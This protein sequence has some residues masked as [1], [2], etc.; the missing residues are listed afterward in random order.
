MYKIKSKRVVASLFVFIICTSIYLMG[1]IRIAGDVVPASLLPLSIAS[2]HSIYLD[3][4]VGF[5]KGNQVNVPF[6]F[7]RYGSHYISAYPITLPLII[8]PIYMMLQIF[9]NFKNMPIGQLIP[10]A[11][12]IGKVISAILTALSVMFFFIFIESLSG[13]RI[14][15]ILLSFIYAFA[16]ENWAIASNSLWQHGFSELM[17]VLCFISILKLE[18]NTQQKA[19]AFLLGLFVS[20]AVS[21]RP[22]DLV[23]AIPLLVYVLLYKRE[24]VLYFLS[25]PFITGGA[26]ITYNLKYFGRLSGGYYSSFNENIFKGVAGLLLS[27]GRGLFVYTPIAIFSLIGL[28]FSF[29]D[30]KTANKIY[31]IAS[32]FIIGQLLLIAKWNMWWGGWTYG[33]RL[34]TDTSPA[35]IL[36]L[37]PVLT[38][39]EKKRLFI[40]LFVIF[41]AISIFIQIMGR[42]C[43]GGYEWNAYFNV[44]KHPDK[45]WNIKESPLLWS[46]EN[47]RIT[48]ST[49]TLPNHMFLKH[50]SDINRN[51]HE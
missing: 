17:I 35:L 27:P 9:Y 40:S 20:L 12:K 44:D 22:T 2:Q 19:F 11:Y 24:F 41:V 37:L 34:L 3:R 43:V 51:F 4:F 10:F 8:S 28:V 16:T 18:N 6:Y 15:S 46:I 7:H 14:K 38:I 47:K 48:N 23:F 25:A 30:I 26:L 45:L 13:D 31:P 21:E 42:F 39:I 32:I 1:P 36:L 29:K 33:P 49:N 50:V 5:Y